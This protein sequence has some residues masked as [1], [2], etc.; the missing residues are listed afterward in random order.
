MLILPQVA[1]CTKLYRRGKTAVWPFRL[2][3]IEYIKFSLVVR[4]WI[5]STF[6]FLLVDKQVWGSHAPFKTKVMTVL[7]ASVKWWSNLIKILQGPRQSHDG[8]HTPH[9]L[10]DMTASTDFVSWHRT[11]IVPNSASISKCGLLINFNFPLAPQG[12]R[13]QWRRPVPHTLKF[14][15]HVHL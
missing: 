2:F 15:P 12:K 1:K 7:N 14:T 10:W 4:W 8:V 5:N 3:P 11:K 13:E 6:L 9:H